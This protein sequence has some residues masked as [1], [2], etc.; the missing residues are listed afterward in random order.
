LVE[1][2]VFD[3][4]EH[5]HYQMQHPMSSYLVAVAVGQY[6]YRMTTSTSGVPIKLYY[7]PQYA[8]NAPWT[9]RYAKRIFDFLE[10]E[11]GIP[12]PWANYKL[13]PVRNFL[14]AGMEN[15]TATIFAESFMTDSIG[16]IDRNFVNVNAHELAHQWFGNSVTEVSSASHWLQEGFA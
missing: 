14:Y 12:Y 15:T 16:F 11:I 8:Q 13:I 1:H 7:E 10:S 3:Q 4:Q 9:Y 6:K 5:W 2:Q